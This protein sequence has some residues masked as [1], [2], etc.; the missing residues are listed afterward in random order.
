M[1][2]KATFLIVLLCCLISS[3]AIAQ[4]LMRSVS[5][6]EAFSIVKMCFNEQ[7]VDYYLCDDP[8]LNVMSEGEKLSF[9]QSN[10]GNGECSFPVAMI[11]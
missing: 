3:S 10:F 1:K 7:D 6:Q 4:Q 5:K 9:L 2:K 8:V 11:F